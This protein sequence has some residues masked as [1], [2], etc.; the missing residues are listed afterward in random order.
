MNEKYN[1]EIQ[2]NVNDILA[3]KDTHR[4][5]QIPADSRTDEAYTCSQ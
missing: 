5:R 1:D 2:K 3:A 4:F